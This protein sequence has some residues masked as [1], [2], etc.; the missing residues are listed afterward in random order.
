MWALLL[1]AANGALAQAKVPAIGDARFPGVIGLAVDATDLTHKVFHVTQRIPLQAAGPVTLLYPQWQVASHAPTGQV[2]RVAGLVVRC[3]GQPLAWTRDPANPFAF[4]VRPPAGAKA[5]DVTF[6]Y[7]SPRAGNL[8]MSRHIVNVGWSNLL[9]YPAG[10]AAQLMAVAAQVRLPAG[11]QFASSLDVEGRDGDVV[12]LKATSLDALVDSP[13]IAG[14]HMRSLSLLD[15]PGAPVM[16]DVFANQAE[17]LALTDTAISPFRH[18]VAEV[19]KMFGANR[20]E[21]YRFLLVLDERMGGPGGIE[22]RRSTE[23][24][25]PA[26]YFA[27][28]QD[29]L[30]NLDLAVHEYIHSWNGTQFLPAGMH[31]RN[32]NEPLQN[33]LLWVDEGLTQYLGKVAAARGG[34]RTLEQALDDLAIDAAR[35]QQQPSRAWKPLRDSVYDPITISGRGIEWPDF[36]GKK[37]YY[38][39]GV[40]LWLAVDLEIRAQTAGRKSLDDF[41]RLFFAPRADASAAVHT[42]TEAD[43]YAALN[44]VSPGDWKRFFDARLD[45]RDGAALVSALERGGYRLVYTDAP[46]ETYSQDAL[47]RGVDDHVFSLGLSVGKAGLLRAVRWDGPAFRAGLTTGARLLRVNGQPYDAPGL[48]AAVASGKPVDLEAEIEGERVEVRIEANPGLRYPR[49]E[50]IQPGSAVIEAIFTAAPA[51]R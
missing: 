12:R 41:L 2:G 46:T 30:R 3:D 40:L 25:M 17:D 15:R 24:F 34:M 8:A 36:T 45:A 44:Q 31:Q 50:R 10:F 18:A 28:P 39:D 29:N 6:T 27:R 9:L 32:F 11:M 42:Y 1:A 35:T 20:R 33:S 7:L 47:D 13:L 19:Q 43:L 26:N 16:L 4:H 51:P 23:A 5:L 21:P 14:L 49:L 22:H 37:D 48:K 38:V